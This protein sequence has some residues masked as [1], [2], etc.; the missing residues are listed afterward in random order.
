MQY[1]VLCTFFIVDHELQRNLCTTWPI[2][3]GR[4]AAVTDQIAGI[5]GLWVHVLFRRTILRLTSVVSGILTET[6][7][8]ISRYYQ[9]YIE[10]V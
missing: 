5:C 3:L 7:K 10:S 8:K 6:L 9:I 1:A 2:S 4:G